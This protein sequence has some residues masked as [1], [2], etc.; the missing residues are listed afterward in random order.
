MVWQILVGQA[1]KK[2]IIW[3][4]PVKKIYLSIAYISFS[5]VPSNAVTK[6]PCGQVCAGICLGLILGSADNTYLDLDYSIKNKNPH[7]I[8]L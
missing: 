8:I 5:W 7:P 3:P 2:Q 1:K 4:F 6:I